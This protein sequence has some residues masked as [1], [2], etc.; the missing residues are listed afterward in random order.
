MTRTQ[1]EEMAAAA[2]AVPVP[3][4]HPRRA[5]GAGMR[6]EVVGAM[7]R[8]V[9]LLDGVGALVLVA[10]LGWLV[11]PEARILHA[12]RPRVGGPGAAPG[13]QADASA[14]AALQASLVEVRSPGDL[15]PGVPSKLLAA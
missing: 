3:P 14:P 4:P 7:T 5:A 8:D 9:K 13:P 1:A 12:A 6:A 10:G 11:R 2:A 15:P